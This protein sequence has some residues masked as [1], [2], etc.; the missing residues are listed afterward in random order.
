ALARKDLGAAEE[1]LA[2]L[3]STGA[4]SNWFVMSAISAKLDAMAALRDHAALEAEAPAYI[5]PRT[6]HEPFALRALG[7]VRE[8]DALLREAL[9]RF[10]QLGLDWHA[11]QT[12]AALAV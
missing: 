12:R 11:E 2:W 1:G 7:I 9:E 10:Q 8:D 3:S 4:A 5:K 6:Y